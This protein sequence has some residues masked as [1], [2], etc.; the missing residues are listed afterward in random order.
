[1]QTQRVGQGGSGGGGNG[2]GLRRRSNGTATQP[3]QSGD[4]GNYG[5]GNNGAHDF[6]HGY[7]RS[8]GGGGGAGAASNE[9]AQLVKH[10]QSVMV[11]LQFTTQV[12]VVETAVAVAH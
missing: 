8:G 9:A 3:N 4:S 11:Q 1:M 7:P 12:A 10:T 6:C 2:H 5:F